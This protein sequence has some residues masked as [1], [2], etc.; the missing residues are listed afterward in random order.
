M[1]KLRLLLADD[2]DALRHA[3]RRV[4][5]ARGMEI[6][7]EAANGVD[8]VEMARHVTVDVVL[9][10]F[11]MP[12]MNGI[13]VARHIG[14]LGSPPVVVILSAY[15]DPSLREEA[16]AAGAVGWLQK[17]L[18]SQELCEEIYLLAGRTAARPL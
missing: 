5:E 3:L 11:S 8:L 6:L 9:T 17:G 14:S 13:E 12:F 16:K 18:S 7:G 10:D 1:Q 4:L 2:E 15:G